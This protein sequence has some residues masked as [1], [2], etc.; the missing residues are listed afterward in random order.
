M[1]HERYTSAADTGSTTTVPQ[2]MTVEEGGRSVGTVVVEPGQTLLEAGAAAGVP[3]PYSC[4]VGNCGDCMVRLR[5]GE[6]TQNEP[7]C[8]TPRQK[9]DGYVLTCVGRPLSKVTLDIADP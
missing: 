4:T 2:E 9:A 3:M 8:L 1:R 7:N 6:V 5:S